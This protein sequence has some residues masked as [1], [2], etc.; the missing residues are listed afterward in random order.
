M[1]GFVDASCWK[2]PLVVNVTAVPVSRSS[3]LPSA[4]SRTGLLMVFVTTAT[5]TAVVDGTVVV[6]ID[7][8]VSRLSCIDPEHIFNS[9]FWDRL[10]RSHQQQ[11]WHE[12]RLHVL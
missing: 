11:N 6:C 2:K 1:I 3:A 8:T 10:L 4:K 12:K 7:I 5:T 9:I